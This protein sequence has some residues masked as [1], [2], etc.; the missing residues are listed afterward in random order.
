MG[1]T[2]PTPSFVT[3]T[4]TP[5]PEDDFTPDFGDFFTPDATPTPSPTPDPRFSSPISTPVVS[6]ATATYNP[7]D[8]SA[9]CIQDACKGLACLAKRGSLV[10]RPFL[11]RRCNF[12]IPCFDAPTSPPD[13]S[14]V[15]L[16]RWTA[17]VFLS[18]PKKLIL[19]DFNRPTSMFVP[20]SG[21]GSAKFSTVAGLF[22][23][24]A[25]VVVSDDGVYLSHHWQHTISDYA[26]KNIP[27]WHRNTVSRPLQN[28]G[29]EEFREGA[30]SD[31][32]INKQFVEEVYPTTGDNFEPLNLVVARPSKPFDPSKKPQ[33]AII[34]I[35]D[36]DA[37][38]AFEFA[39]TFTESGKVFQ[40]VVKDTVPG[41]TTDPVVVRYT[42]GDNAGPSSGNPEDFHGK[43]IVSFDKNSRKW[44]VWMLGSSSGEEVKPI[45][46]SA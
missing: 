27:Q 8:P 7:V 20:F 10:E 44:Q 14:P 32:H 36:D 40:Q 42:N 18:N 41:L 16:N 1:E 25:V 23:C 5:T 4:P 31:E 9:G 33:A 6:P 39:N 38:N 2:T 17:E 26:L 35:K 30:N 34:M 11:S 13:T 15:G 24:T 29:L 37:P 3:P 28:L 12:L 45:L 46:Q 43:V 22:G 21:D 19:G